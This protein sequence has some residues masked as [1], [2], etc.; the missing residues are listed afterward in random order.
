MNCR[1]F[2]N[3]VRT[4][5]RAASDSEAV[6]Y[7]DAE[8]SRILIVLAAKQPEQPQVR[9]HGGML[10]D[11]NIDPASERQREIG[12]RGYESLGERARRRNDRRQQRVGD[13]GERVIVVGGLP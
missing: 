9:G 13:D 1:L 4:Q 11:A 8:P 3:T 5:A 6:A 10:G 2:L 12:F 7:T